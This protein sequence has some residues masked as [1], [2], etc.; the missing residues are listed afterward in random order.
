[1]T[2][3]SPVPD[4][5]TG[6]PAPEACTIL[7]PFLLSPAMQTGWA[8]FTQSWDRLPA[9][10]Y[11]GDGGRYRQRRHATFRLAGRDLIRLPHRPHFQD[12]AFNPLNGGVERWFAPIED[13]IAQTQCFRQILQATARLIGQRAPD[14]MAGWIIE[15]HQF[16]ILAKPD[17]P[18]LPT[19]EGMHRDGREWV[20]ILLANS[21]N[22]SGGETTIEDATGRMI[23]QHCLREPGEA[24][25]LDDRLVRHATS[26][27]TPKLAAA[28][29]WRDTLV[30]TF[31]QASA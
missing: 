22:I 3:A 13:A 8:G 28:P 20:L 23:A 31:T 19:P 6:H 29:A 1:L 17:A 15:A 2:I 11:M 10:G 9:D 7:P 16:R 18:G 14:S 27:I 4:N 5:P 12:I 24:L 26:P 30:V 21:S 25:L